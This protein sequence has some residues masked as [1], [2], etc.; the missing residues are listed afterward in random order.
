MKIKFDK[1]YTPIE[2]ANHCYDKVIELIGDDNITDIIEPSV[3][4]GSFLNHP[5]VKT[6]P[7]LC[8]DIEP[9]IIGDNIIKGDWLT[10]P[11]DY[12]KGRLVI[13][14]PPYGS[15]MN[16]AQ[17]FFKKSID[18]CDYIA[19]ILPI[20]QLDNTQSLYEFDLIYSEDLG[21]LEYSGKS[22]HCC[23]NIYRRPKSGDLNKKTINKLSFFKN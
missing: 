22:L 14:N 1:Y 10:Y 2:I 7:I 6:K 3:G 9:E 11:I 12:K 13:G 5:F 20:S 8:I 4:N 18:V 15:R 23:L 19:F 17:K 21:T 16:M